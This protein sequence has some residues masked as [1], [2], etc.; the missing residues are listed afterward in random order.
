M[1]LDPKT[2]ALVVIDLQ[3]GLQGRDLAPYTF[4]EVVAVNQDL[5]GKFRAAGAPVVLVNVAFAKDGADALKTPTDRGM[6]MPP[7]GYPAEFSHLVDGLSRDGDIHVTK[8]NWGAFYGTELDVHLR[9][10]GVTTVVVTGVATNMG[11]ESTARQ[12]HE[13]SYAV[14]IPEDACSTMSPEW[15]DFAV[16]TI[17][18]MLGRVV[19]SADVVLG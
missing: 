16:K 19:K 2:T 18:P 15:H 7:G 5:L 12:A 10:R 6:T 4:D 14:V 1:N 8:R 13:A 17:F 3:K 9:R 11:V